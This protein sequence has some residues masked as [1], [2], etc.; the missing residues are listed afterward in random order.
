MEEIAEEIK[1]LAER[2]N[3][4]VRIDNNIIRLYDDKASVIK[5]ALSGVNDIIEL[6]YTIAE[7]HPYWGLLY[8]TI[9]IT[10]RLL[11]KWD[12]TLNTEDIEE[13][14][15]RIEEVRNMLTRFR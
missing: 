9:E 1:R 8:N 4:Q 6:A 15:W 14:L 7:H 3:L 2:Y 12:D 5:R 10:R 13:L 11:E